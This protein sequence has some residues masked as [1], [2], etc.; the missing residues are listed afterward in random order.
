MGMATIPAVM[1]IFL[2]TME[3]GTAEIVLPTTEKEETGRTTE[4]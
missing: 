1:G 4:R 3:M 2:G